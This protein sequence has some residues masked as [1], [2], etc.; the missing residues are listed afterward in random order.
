[1]VKRDTEGKEGEGIFSVKI[2]EDRRNQQG[3]GEK[4]NR[5]KKRAYMYGKESYVCIIDNLVFRPTS[6]FLF[7]QCTNVVQ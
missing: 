6:Q 5:R 2:E 7:V 1:M 4:E 3:E